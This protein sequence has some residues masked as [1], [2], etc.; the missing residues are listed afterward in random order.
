MIDPF[1]SN[2]KHDKILHNETLTTIEKSN[3]I[4]TFS[5]MILNCTC[6]KVFSKM[7]KF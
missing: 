3:T 7:E 2:C 1:C 5:C 4:I 6:T